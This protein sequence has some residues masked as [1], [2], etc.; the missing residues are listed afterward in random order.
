MPSGDEALA[1]TMPVAI[2]SE[3]PSDGPSILAGSAANILGLV[4]ANFLGFLSGLITARTLGEK[5]VGA[6]AVIFGI[7]EFGRSVSNFSHNPSILE[8]HRGRPANRVL[9]TSLVF[10]LL[11]SA[12]FVSVI[13]ASVPQLAAV[14]DVPE[15]A[16]VVASTLFFAGSIF[17]VGSA[18]FEAEN[19]MFLRTAIAS[20][21]PIAGLFAVI[22][23]VLADAYSVHTA[24]VT[25]LVGTLAM[26]AGILVSWKGPW[27]LRFD[28]GIARYYVRYGSPLIIS[29]LLTQA[30]IWTDT[31]MVSA[32]LGNAD[33]GVYNVAFQLT[34]VIVTASVAIGVA[35]LPAMSRLAGRGEDTSFA[36][37]RATLLSLG[38]A[39]ALGATYVLFGRWFLGIY[40]PGFAE[41][42]PALLV[43][44][45][46]GLA[47]AVAVPAAAALTVHGR[48]HVLMMLSLA[49]V[50]LNVPLNYVL[51][52]K[53]GII[54]AAV[55]TTTVYVAGLLAMWYVVHRSTGAT[56]LSRAVLSE[57]RP[58]LRRLRQS[59]R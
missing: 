57:V 46:F 7:V 33:A 42:Y 27:S 24:V 12:L 43:L 23:F 31:L 17:D 1:A 37:Q 56:P 39:A 50:S 36:Y 29:T 44:T 4:L 45:V 30:L 15:S 40:G 52:P 48:A 54:G 14:F 25:T 59:R 38:L 41:G 3:I 18:R 34:F 9:G 5:G 35:V 53:V 26:S 51:L 28:A 58:T 11:G 16:L 8:Y 19:R 21:G 49:Q 6:L 22:I 20:L 2:G 13:V 32:L 55:S 47:A 10:K